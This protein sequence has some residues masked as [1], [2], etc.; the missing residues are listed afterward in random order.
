M[1]TMKDV[2][3]GTKHGIELLLEKKK[4]IDENDEGR[5][6]GYQKGN[7]VFIGKKVKMKMMKDV[8]S[9]TKR[10]LG[11]YREKGQDQSDEGRAIGYKKG[12][13]FFLLGKRSR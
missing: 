6:I 13:V 11:F 1:K 7:W 2:P 4:I 5:A 3:S 10:E 12:I 9:G 8:P